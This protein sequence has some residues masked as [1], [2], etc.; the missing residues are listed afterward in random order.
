MD[1]VSNT[2]VRKKSR[3]VIA[4]SGGVDSAV[5][6]ALLKEH[7][8]DVIGIS[9][10]LWDY[11]DGEKDSF[12]SCCSLDDLY[13]ARR[14][15]DRLGIP[16]YVVNFEEAFSKSVVNY[17]VE[18]YING[19]TPN[20]CLKCN[21]VLKFDVL[22][23]RA[24]ELE[25]DYLATGHYA[26]VIYD[27]KSGRYLLLRGKDAS[28]D[29]SYFLFTM[30]QKQLAKTIFPLG[31]LT[32]TEVRKLA[33]RFNLNVAD[34]KDSQEI[35]FAPEDYPSFIMQRAGNAIV[36][37]GEIVDIS[38]NVI[39]M[40]DGLYKYTI[41]Q[42]KG[43]GV[44]KGEP[45]YVLKIDS[46]KNRLVVGAEEGLLSNGLVA[47]ETN[48]IGIP[49]PKDEIEVVAKI[50][51]RHNGIEAKVAPLDS[52]RVEVLFKRP[53]KSVT[54]GQAVVFYKGDEVIGGGWIEE[55]RRFSCGLS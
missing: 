14:V 51:Y 33:A 9:M 12:G 41:G 43:I 13:D 45:L 36:A 21:Q 3:V 24:L 4:M 49:F 30:T 17:F 19:E 46:K 39:G 26:R 40:H 6:A 35:C 31:D 50:R 11:T 42:R 44:A 8:Y 1:A 29:Q 15:A 28:K 7:G 55:D 47:K 23:R 32:K 53:A 34:K 52:K 37:K 38:G 2:R 25:A 22:L 10:Q 5:A 18:G 20:P 54:P 48:W 27:D 16:F